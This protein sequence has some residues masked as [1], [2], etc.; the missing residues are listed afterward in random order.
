MAANLASDSDDSEAARAAQWLLDVELDK[1]WRDAMI[2]K[3]RQGGHVCGEEE[4]ELIA[5]CC[6]LLDTTRH[7]GTVRMLR[8]SCTV[9]S[10]WTKRNKPSGMLIGR[11]ETLIRASP[12]LI[13]AYQMNVDSK[14]KLSRR[15]KGELRREILEVPNLHHLVLGCEMK[16]HGCLA[17]RIFLASLVW[18]KVCDAPPTFIWAFVPIDRH[19][20]LPPEQEAHT[21]RGSTSRYLRLTQISEHVTHLDYA[22][23]IDFKGTVPK[24]ATNRRV[25][26]FTMRLPYEIQLYFLQVKRPSECIADDG[27]YIGHM[28]TDMA[29]AA[30]KCDRASTIRAFVRRMAV[31]RECP[32]A[33]LDAM[34]VGI[35]VG[36]ASVSGPSKGMPTAAQDPAALTAADAENF[37]RGLKSTVRLGATPIAAVDELLRMHPALGVMAQ[38]HAWFRP[39][40]ETIAKRQGSD[41]A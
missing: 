39:M 2:L 23:Y 40:L 9:L 27:K 19:D 10:A 20:R 8:H 41:P 37:G 4:T 3:M 34:L 12:E 17:N 28:V 35:F 38:Q 29:E 14:D 31:L 6:S 1:A 7:P 32:L 25:S 24:W 16:L 5:K 21:V 15:P 33:S 18:R 13:I 22:C 30:K 26:Q 11:V 36:K